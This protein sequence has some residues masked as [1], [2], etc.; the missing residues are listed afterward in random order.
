[1]SNT[2][3]KI[4]ILS[5]KYVFFKKLNGFGELSTPAVQIRRDIE[6]IL[7]IAKVRAYF[8]LVVPYMGP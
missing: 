7:K 8:P 4:K 3:N 6:K 5:R 1:M 2:K